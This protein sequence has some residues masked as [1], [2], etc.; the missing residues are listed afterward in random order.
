MVVTLSSTGLDPA[1]KLGATLGLRS[2]VVLGA[3]LADLFGEMAARSEARI[4]GTDES[5]RENRDRGEAGPGALS[6]TTSTGWRSLLDRAI[7]SSR[8]GRWPA[9]GLAVRHSCAP[10]FL[11]TSTDPGGFALLDGDKLVYLRAADP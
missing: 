3:L 11:S 7:S 4:P 8:A 2:G 1:A 9:Q 10:L 5:L 6:G